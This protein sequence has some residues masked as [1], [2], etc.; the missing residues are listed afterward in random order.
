MI[1]DD[2][3]KKAAREVL[4]VIEQRA[5]EAA[6]AENATPEDQALYRYIQRAARSNRHWIFEELKNGTTVQTI[7][8]V[9][10]TDMS[11]Q[12]VTILGYCDIGEENYKEVLQESVDVFQRSLTRNLQHAALSNQIRSMRWYVEK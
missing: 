11:N 6:E 4:A 2:Q 10:M 8:S 7:I 5:K 1:E 3:Y 12:I 9:L